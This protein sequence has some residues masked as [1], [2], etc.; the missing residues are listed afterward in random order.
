M[1]KDRSKPWRC[2]QKEWRNLLSRVPP[3]FCPILAEFNKTSA[4]HFGFFGCFGFFVSFLGLL[5]PIVFHSFRTYLLNMS[6][7]IFYKT[8]KIPLV[9]GDRIVLRVEV[10]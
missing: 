7:F 5:S 1:N 10:K 4:F 3:F 6:L 8:R 2:M 9:E